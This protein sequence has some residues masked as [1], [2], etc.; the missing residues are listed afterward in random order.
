MG[1][2]RQKML[3]FHGLPPVIGGLLSNF[4]RRAPA[5]FP[6]PTVEVRTATVYTFAVNSRRIPLTAAALL[7]LCLRPVA[8]QTRQSIGGAFERNYKSEKRAPLPAPTPTSLTPEDRKRVMSD[9]AEGFYS[10]GVRAKTSGRTTDAI[11]YFER[12]LAID[13]NH[14]AARAQLADLKK[15]HQAAA[16]KTTS[17]ETTSH[18]LTKLWAEG[19]AA[20]RRE[21]WDEAQLA[22]RKILAIE[23]DNKKAHARLDMAEGKLFAKLRQRGDEREKAS[24][25]GG[26][27]QLYQQALMHGDDESLEQHVEN[28]KQQLAES[29]RK[30][31]DQIYADA[32]AASQQGNNDR[33]LM[34]C[35]QALRTDPSN[36]QAQRMLERLERHGR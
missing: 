7:A 11:A 30:K 2:A 12:V 26:A 4:P 1:P 14:A 19:D 33:A 36:L 15:K 27:V 22:Y 21:N 32:L 34:L 24:D 28:L 8:A 16:R 29:N 9:V 31:S 35:R 13:P 25:L 5:G 18:L 17:K 3:R 23:P 10:D 20:T 6:S